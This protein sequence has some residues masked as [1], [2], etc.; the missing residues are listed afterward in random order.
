MFC[1]AK[2]EPVNEVSIDAAIEDERRTIKRTSSH[3]DIYS[4]LE[5][6]N[7][8]SDE[9]LKRCKSD[10]RNINIMSGSLSKLENQNIDLSGWFQR[11][12]GED[13]FMF[14]SLCDRHRNMLERSEHKIEYE[15]LTRSLN[16]KLIKNIG[17]LRG[18]KSRL[19]GALIRMSRVRSFRN[20]NYQVTV[21]TDKY[22]E[23]K[24]GQPSEYNNLPPAAG[25][26]ECH[27]FQGKIS[28][29]YLVR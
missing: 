27:Y 11:E 25:E 24:Q 1:D 23:K 15:S 21:D 14:E 5:A 7:A 29:S 12:T 9:A 2:P 20:G 28:V 22:R 16:K 4:K 13:D 17:K 19:F 3:C 26:R 8:G 18:S 10:S 6:R